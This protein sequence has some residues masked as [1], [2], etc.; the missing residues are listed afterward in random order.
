MGRLILYG[1]I[2][3]F[4]SGISFFLGFVTQAFLWLSDFM[5][6]PYQA[7]LS[8]FLNDILSVSFASLSLFLIIV[9]ADFVRSEFESRPGNIKYDPIPKPKISV[10]MTAWNDE[11]SIYDAV[12]DFKKQDGVIEVVVVENNST[13]NTTKLARKAGAKVVTETRPGYGS[14]CIRALKEA[15][16][17]ANIIVLVEGDMTF[18]GYDVKKLV[19]YLDNVDMAVGTRTTQELLN[20]R[21]QLGWFTIWGNLFLAKLIQIKYW[22]FK[23]WGSVRLTDVGCTLRAIRSE[24]LKKIINKLNVDS[25]HFSPHMI[26]VALDNKLKIIEIP[27]TFKERVGVSK[28]AGSNNWK[29]FKVGLKMMRT[30][31]S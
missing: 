19:P 22:N 14:V 16:R 13:D 25:D 10:V 27:V 29:A 2:L 31:F 1:L 12:M 6:S 30:I 9:L 8:V 15:S 23:M 17:E 7:Y 20:Q 5:H 28:G 11:E 24:S 21:T 3:L 18:N 4:I 26:I